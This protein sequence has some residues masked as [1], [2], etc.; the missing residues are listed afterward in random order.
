M[1]PRVPLVLAS[2][3]AASFATDA[4]DSVRLPGATAVA[5]VFTAA[6]VAVTVAAAAAAAAASGVCVVVVPVPSSPGVEDACT[7]A[8]VGWVGGV[9]RCGVAGLRG[10]A[11]AW[12]YCS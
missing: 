5:A 7:R 9:S 1:A 12:V 6:A 10:C 8:R 3:A 11:L 4:G 2:A